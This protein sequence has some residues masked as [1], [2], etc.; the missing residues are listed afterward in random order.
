MLEAIVIVAWLL[1]LPLTVMALAG[2]AYGRHLRIADAREM[3]IQ[4]TTVGN[5]ETVNAIIESIHAYRLSFPY[6][7]WVVA[8]PNSGTGYRGADRVLVVPADFVCRASYKA[9]AL[10]YVRRLRAR[11]GL[12]DRDLKI[13]FLDDD[14]LPTKSYIEKGFRADY[15]ICQGIVVPRND[16][17]RFL[18]YM[19]D[20]RTLNCLIFC[21]V[22]QAIGY[23]IQVHGEG[24]CVRSSA[25]QLVTWDYP[26]IASEDLVF[27][28]MAARK[29]LHWGF[30][31][32]RIYITSPWT[33]RDFFKQRRRWIWGNI[34][35]IRFV[36]PPGAKIRLVAKYLLGFAGYG[37]STTGVV[38]ARL[39][40]LDIP[41]AI[42]P[43]LMVSLVAFLISFAVSGWV[44][45]GGRVPVVSVLLSFLTCAVSVF[46]LL[47]GI[48]RGNPRRFEV[49]QKVAVGASKPAQ[50][51]GR[52]TGTE[53]T[54]FLTAGGMIFGIG[55]FAFMV[56]SG[57]LVRLGS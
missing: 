16:N 44:N 8:E 9:R 25:E 6:Q 53:P 10:E 17:G 36:L 2:Y 12:D 50:T 29:G 11:E 47:V 15:D 51:Q 32:G 22:F 13:L 55:L 49:I 54:R 45:S 41:D 57:I 31:Y 43:L 46:V 56:L 42:R 14:S 48:V 7:I 39:G 4:I 52:A 34:H 27:G 37:A 23:P 18:S 33:F 24:L 30:F 20:L 1:P 21:S 5:Q 28:Q 19:D 3:I 40:V 26:V 35:A 38:L